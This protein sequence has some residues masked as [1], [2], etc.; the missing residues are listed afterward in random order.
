MDT[1]SF[2]SLSLSN[3]GGVG[4][5]VKQNM[6]YTKIENLT[7]STS[8]FEGLWIELHNNK[9]RNVVCGII[10]R[11]PSGNSEDFLDYLQNAIESI[12]NSNKCCI[13][14]GDFNLNLLNFESHPQTEKFLNS[15]STYFFLPQIIKSTRIT[16]HSATL[17]DNIFLNSAEHFKW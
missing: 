14:L 6:S 9:Q 3:A 4:L 11:H 10:Y 15:L 2:L 17:I 13:I 7:T 8:D 5:Y 16:H 1:I 12:Y